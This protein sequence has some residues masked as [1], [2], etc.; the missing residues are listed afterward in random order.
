MLLNVF[1]LGREGRGQALS[2]LSTLV[3][4]IQKTTSFILLNPPLSEIRIFFFILINK[5]FQELANF[6][7]YC[8]NV[9]FCQI[10]WTP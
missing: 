7:L 9:R 8:A 5:F 10:V 3:I 4:M 6:F 1:V 2:I